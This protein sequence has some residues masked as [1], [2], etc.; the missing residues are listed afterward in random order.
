MIGD[1]GFNRPTISMIRV[2]TMMLGEID[3]LGT[4]LKPLQL[5]NDPSNYISYQIIASIVFLIVFVVLMP[6]LLVNLMIGLAVGDIETVRRNA[7]LKRLTMQVQ[8]HTDLERKLP[9]R[10][11]KYVDKMYVCEYPNRKCKSSSYMVLIC[12]LYINYNY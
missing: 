8:L 6:I 11:L 4:F 10:F 7:H 2:G 9:K 1:K 3:F 5:I 12:D